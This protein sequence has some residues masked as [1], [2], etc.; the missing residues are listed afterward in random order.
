MSVSRKQIAAAFKAAKKNLSHGGPEGYGSS[1]ICWA[2]EDGNRNGDY[3]V[4]EA[5]YA[6]KAVI[7]RR[8]GGCVV[9]TEWLQEN[10]PGFR[11]AY[12]AGNGRQLV[13]AYRHRWVDALIKEFGG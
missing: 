11:Q 1:Y 10:V 7:E 2:I 5:A 4:T 13:Q 6:A 9:V 12:N 8:L 3:R